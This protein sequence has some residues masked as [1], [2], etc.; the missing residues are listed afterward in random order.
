MNNNKTRI[1]R[2]KDILDS[3]VESEWCVVD[4][5][6]LFKFKNN[7]YSIGEVESEYKVYN[8]YDEVE[9]YT[10]ET[11]MDK[12]LVIV[13]RNKELKFY[14]QNYDEMFDIKIV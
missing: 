3:S 2:S 6:N 13:T 11:Y 1:Q 10:N 8:K 7:L 4:A 12:V 9:D 5:D 14:N